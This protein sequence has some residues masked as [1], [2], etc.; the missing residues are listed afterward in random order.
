MAP[1]VWDERE[2]WEEL[3]GSNTMRDRQGPCEFLLGQTLLGNSTKEIHKSCFQSGDNGP[4]PWDD[5]WLLEPIT[6]I[7]G[8]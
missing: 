7:P 4:V 2:P 5:S 6:E 3:A 1:C 8:Q